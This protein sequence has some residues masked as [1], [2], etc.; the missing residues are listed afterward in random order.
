MGIIIKLV[1]VNIRIKW[2][3]LNK[4]FYFKSNVWRLVNFE[5]M[6][7]LIVSLE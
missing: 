3:I 7:I 6:F 2:D 5:L 4:E 1:Y